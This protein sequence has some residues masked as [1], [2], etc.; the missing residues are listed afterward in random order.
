MLPLPRGA[1]NLR[2]LTQRPSGAILLPDRRYDMARMDLRI[3]AEPAL[4][5][6]DQRLK[7]LFDAL[8]NLNT[9][10]VLASFQF[11][12]VPNN[13]PNPGPNP[14]RYRYEWTT[15]PSA[16]YP[17]GVTFVQH[18]VFEPPSGR[19]RNEFEATA[20]IYDD[21]L[22]EHRSVRAAILVLHQSAGLTRFDMTFL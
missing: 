12:A 1:R 4:H 21:D 7:A 9:S 18:I 22:P 16:D 5:A 19:Y 13:P 20:G 14:H 11:R 17:S 10:V 3:E 6:S 8:A 15:R 2:R